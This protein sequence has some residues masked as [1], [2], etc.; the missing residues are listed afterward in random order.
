MNNTSPEEAYES[1]TKP[2][3]EA[4]ESAMK[5]ASEAYEAAKKAKK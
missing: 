5:T 2:A 3:W 4:Y 1:A